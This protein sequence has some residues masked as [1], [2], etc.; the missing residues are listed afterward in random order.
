MT[1]LVYEVS[2]KGTASETLRAGFEAFDVRVG[3]GQTVVRCTPGL[4]PSVLE[5]LE[6]FGLELL[7]VRLM[8]E[9]PSAD[10]G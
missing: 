3:H 8:A 4:L 1:D 7:E 2:F 9:S 10:L 5:Q 6:S